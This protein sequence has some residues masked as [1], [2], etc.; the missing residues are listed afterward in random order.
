MYPI[1]AGLFRLKVHG[2]GQGKFIDSYLSND[3]L[4]SIWSNFY[5]PDLFTVIYFEFFIIVSIP[6]NIL[7]KS[8]SNIYMFLSVDSEKWNLL[9]ESICI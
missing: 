1:A 7:D 8:Q 4:F 9:S 6:M 5:F 3:L 2:T